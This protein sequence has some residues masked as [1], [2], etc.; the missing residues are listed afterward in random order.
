ME[1]LDELFAKERKIEAAQKHDNE[2]LLYDY[3]IVLQTAEGRRVL[4]DIMSMCHLYSLSMTG[5]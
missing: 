5:N 4:W 1:L 2:Q 3:R